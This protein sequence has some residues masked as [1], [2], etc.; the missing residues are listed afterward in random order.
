MSAGCILAKCRTADR[1]EFEVGTNHM[2]LKYQQRHYPRANAWL[3]T[4]KQ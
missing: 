4:I 1:A 2:D 3:A